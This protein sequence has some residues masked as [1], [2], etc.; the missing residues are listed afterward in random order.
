MQKK[1]ATVIG[2]HQ[3]EDF[4]NN[5]FAVHTL[6]AICDITDESNKLNKNLSVISL[7]SILYFLFCVNSDMG[8]NSFTKLNEQ[9]RI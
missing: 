8:T 9:Y 4:K 5:N 1:L 2:E 3:S 7:E 6:S